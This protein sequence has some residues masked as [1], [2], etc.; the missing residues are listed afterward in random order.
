MRVPNRIDDEKV[1]VLWNSFYVKQKYVK[2]IAKN[3]EKYKKIKL[4]KLQKYKLMTHRKWKNV[5]YDGHP[6]NDL[7]LTLVCTAGCIL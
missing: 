1:N 2:I 7:F 3:I 6:L 5:K 4:K